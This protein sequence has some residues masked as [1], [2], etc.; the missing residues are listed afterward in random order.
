MTGVRI[1]ISRY[2]GRDAL[3]A[4]FVTATRASRLQQ[5]HDG[6][7]WS[8]SR[9]PKRDAPPD[10][11][12]IGR[13]SISEHWG[14]DALVAWFET[15]TR[16]SRLQRVHDG[17]RWSVSRV[18][19]GD[20]SPDGHSIPPALRRLRDGFFEQEGREGRKVGGGGLMTCRTTSLDRTVTGA[21]T[22]CRPAGSAIGRSLRCGRR[23]S[24]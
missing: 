9:V 22:C 17:C 7:R 3:V 18:H 19:K 8:V 20:A 6:C 23:R 13:I 4:W 15:A 24:P 10:R 21:A 12:S 11:H 5:V 1:I 2:W 16:A 14:R